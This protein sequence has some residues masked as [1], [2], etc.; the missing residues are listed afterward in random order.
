VG[1]A[2]GVNGYLYLRRQITQ[3]W[4]LRRILPIASGRSGLL[5]D[6]PLT[7]RSS[8]L[9]Y[10]CRMEGLFA[11]RIYWVVDHLL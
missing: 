11:F 4:I 10:C 6:P 5:I 9:D 2:R 8:R 1:T 7:R 3:S